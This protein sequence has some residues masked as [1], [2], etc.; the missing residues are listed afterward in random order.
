MKSKNFLLCAS[1]WDINSRH[2]GIEKEPR[3]VEEHRDR[4]DDSR[5]IVRNFCFG[6]HLAEEKQK[7]KAK[8]QIWVVNSWWRNFPRKSRLIFLHI[9][10]DY[11]FSQPESQSQVA[12]TKSFCPPQSPELDFVSLEHL[13]SRQKVEFL[14]SALARRGKEKQMIINYECFSS[15][16]CLANSKKPFSYSRENFCPWFR[17]CFS[18][19]TTKI[20]P[21]CELPTNFKWKQSFF[22]GA[23]TIKSTFRP[24]GL[25]TRVEHD[26]IPTLTVKTCGK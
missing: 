22:P 26:W 13:S 10:S 25:A 3:R 11:Y 23:S 5:L 1:R 14:N 6:K 17:K 24:I 9:F 4:R 15:F 16:D 21:P 20:P 19:K 7:A 8:I 2:S 12:P 18:I